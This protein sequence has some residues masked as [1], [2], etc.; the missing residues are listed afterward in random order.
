MTKLKEKTFHDVKKALYLEDKAVD[1]AMKHS[2]KN[3]RVTI[4][5]NNNVPFHIYYKKYKTREIMRDE[6]GVTNTNWFKNV[7]KK[8]KKETNKRSYKE[9]YIITLYKGYNIND[10]CTTGIDIHVKDVIKLKKHI[11]HAYLTSKDIV[12]LKDYNFNKIETYRVDYYLTIH[13]D[14]KYSYPLF[15]PNIIDPILDLNP[16]RRLLPR[17]RNSEYLSDIGWYGSS[18]WPAP[19]NTLDPAPTFTLAQ[20]VNGVYNPNVVYMFIFDTG[21]TIHNFLNINTNRSRNFVPNNDNIVNPSDW[22]DRHG[23]GTHVAG[24]AAGRRTPF[25]LQEV[26][27]KRIRPGVAGVATGNQVIGYKVLGD[28]GLGQGT[29]FNNAQNAVLEF[30]SNRQHRGASIVVNMSL[31]APNATGHFLNKRDFTN[32]YRIIPVVV[33]A[34]NNNINTGVRNVQPA[35]SRGSIVVGN[36]ERNIRRWPESNYG[37]RVDIFAPGTAIPSTDVPRFPGDPQNLFRCRTGTSMAAPVVAGAV[38]LLLANRRNRGQS[39]P[40]SEEILRQLI[41]TSRPLQCAFTGRYVL[42]ENNMTW[43]I[44]CTNPANPPGT[45][46]RFLFIGDTNIY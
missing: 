5:L 14:E 40:D 28:D 16:L 34:G 6:Q 13:V 4:K 21:V 39:R 7:V 46:N 35:N 45:T 33:A 17:C 2:S 29:W 15:L 41:N 9:S 22:T 8:I 44:N 32:E 38:A 11:V 30:A 10:L 18:R 26:F 1:L 23:H 20:E 43:D 42:R 24:I 25:P 3:K 37:Q 36:A 31:G 19:R 27:E 12:K